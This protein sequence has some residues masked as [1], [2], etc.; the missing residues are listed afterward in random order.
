MMPELL[1]ESNL[2]MS[3]SKIH[4]NNYYAIAYN[5]SGILQLLALQCYGFFVEL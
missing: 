2:L 1:L 5:T 3:E 4:Y